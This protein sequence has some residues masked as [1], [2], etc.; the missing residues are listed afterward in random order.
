MRTTL[1]APLAVLLVGLP[2]ALLADAP[3]LPAL[4]E[5]FERV[6]RLD[7]P[8]Q[9]ISGWT[10]LPSSDPTVRTFLAVSDEGRRGADEAVVR[11]SVYRVAFDVTEDGGVTARAPVP[12]AL[13]LGDLV[14]DLDPAWSQQG[15]WPPDLESCVPIPG[16]PDRYILGGERGPEDA[17][18]GGANRLY[19]V[20]YP[21][22]DETRAE[23]LAYLR[24]PDVVDDT[25]NDRLEGVVVLPRGEERWWPLFAFKERTPVRDRAPGFFP[26]LLH[27]TEDGFRIG[28]A[29]AASFR[30]LPTLIADPKRLSSQADA[31]RAPDGSVWILDRWRREIHVADARGDGVLLHRESLDYFEPIADV[32]G[33]TVAMEPKAPGSRHRGYGRHE[34]LCFDEHGWLWM[35]ADLG[36][37]SPST[38]TVFRPRSPTVETGGD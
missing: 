4:S 18:D 6:A 22:G 25:I 23:L 8:V 10:P 13:D 24:L 16:L 33:E 11:G 30:A 14:S 28:P 2:A 19:V 1:L 29:R 31:C 27:E 20:R 15:G 21:A 37:G 35:A 26:L 7:V 38:V 9:E 34:A 32:Q 12:V 3:D 17:S 5:R 36:G